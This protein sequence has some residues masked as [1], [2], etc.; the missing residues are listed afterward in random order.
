MP[1]PSFASIH[2]TPFDDGSTVFGPL[3]DT[4]LAF[5]HRSGALT[6]LERIG[7]LG[8]RVASL[9]STPEQW[10]RHG[11]RCLERWS[12]ML[13]GNVPTHAVHGLASLADVRAV[14]A[15][16]PDQQLVDPAGRL[17]GAALGGACQVEA[18]AGGGWQPLRGTGVVESPTPIP[19]HPWNLLDQLSIRLSDDLALL[20]GVPGVTSDQTPLGTLMRCGA[21]TVDPGVVLD[22]RKGPI[23]LWDGC[24][25]GA[26]AVLQGP[27]IIGTGS[28]V[29]PCALVKPHT[30]I[31]PTCR[32]GCEIGGSIVYGFSNAVHDGHIGDS[33]V[34]EWVNVG[35][36]TCVS[37]LLNTYGE[38]VASLGPQL[39]RCPTG[40]THYGGVLGDHA[41][42]AI[43]AAIP[44]GFSIG[45]GSMVAVSRAPQTVGAFGWITPDR[46]A[47]NRI[48]RVLQTES[49]MMARR[50]QSMGAAHRAF[51]EA[52]HIVSAHG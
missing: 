25:I 43:L 17:V 26:N 33:L 45:V 19:T 18:L 5:E 4:R 34:G 51:L 48:D 7:A 29:S 37:N 15:L 22:A 40:R 35:A 41:K 1:A 31:G 28:S 24:H 38:V 3:S 21:V 12:A 2:I 20:A 42:I 52:L 6:Q 36:G 44:T 14:L 30:V 10:V 50:Q 8:A 49:A 46:T 47:V 16:T 13:S 39:P 32:I 27:C 23:A 9:S 11:A